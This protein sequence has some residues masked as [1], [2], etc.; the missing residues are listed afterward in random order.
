MKLMV[1]SLK[2]IKI[3]TEAIEN[4]FK[5]LHQENTMNCG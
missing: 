4:D 2:M 5:K 1:T 3:N